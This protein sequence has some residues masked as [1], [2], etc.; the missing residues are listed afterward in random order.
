MTDLLLR[1][2]VG[3]LDLVEIVLFAILVFKFRKRWDKRTLLAG[4]VVVVATFVSMYLPGVVFTTVRTVVNVAFCL[5]LIEEDKFKS[6]LLYIFSANYVSIIFF[7]VATFINIFVQSPIMSDNRSLLVIGLVDCALILIAMAA[8]KKMHIEPM[9]TSMI[10]NWCLVF[11]GLCG[12]CGNLLMVVIYSLVDS[13]M[14]PSREINILLGSMI[15]VDIAFCLSGI[16]ILMLHYRNVL[17]RN[18]NLEKQSMLE[19][20]VGYY[21]QVKENDQQVHRIKH[22]ITEHVAMISNQL[23]NNR[24]EEAKE[25]VNQILGKIED[26]DYTVNVGNIFVSGII[27]RKKSQA[28]RLGIEFNARGSL[29]DTLK[30]DNYDL[31]TIMSNLLNNAIEYYAQNDMTEKKIDVI[32]CMRG[33]TLCIEVSN[34]VAESDVDITKTSKADKSNHGYGL[35]NVRRTVMKY[36]GEISFHLQDNIFRVFIMVEDSKK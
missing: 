22:D 16:I 29:P 21:E 15:V 10:E 7:P 27:N 6:L 17:R 30:V 8:I 11:T 14:A 33:K 25:Y 5:I 34:T 18:E 2:A 19:T 32:V 31:C 24:I 3:L 12:F 28:K 4:I 36:Q 23:E 26:V 1:L 20:M 35:D 13:N 9:D